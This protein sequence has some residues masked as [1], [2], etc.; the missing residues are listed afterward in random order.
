MS[1]FPDHVE[2]I[3][4]ARELGVNVDDCFDI[5]GNVTIDSWGCDELVYTMSDILEKLSDSASKESKLQQ[6]NAELREML[7]ESRGAIS[8]CSIQESRN[9]GTENRMKINA[10]NKLLSKIDSVINKNY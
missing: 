5:N 4:T 6:E 10:L 3:N 9:Y 7:K 1:T 2:N 8:A